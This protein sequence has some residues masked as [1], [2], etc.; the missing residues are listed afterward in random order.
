MRRFLRYAGR[1]VAAA[2]V[3]VGCCALLAAVVVPRIAGATPYTVLT[4]SMRPT[5]PP[6]SI[7]VVRPNQPIALGD[8]I[9]FQL[10]SGEPEVVT[11]RV[12]EI[13]FKTDGTP[14]YRTRGDANNADDR[15]EV[16][17]V[18]IRGVVWYHIPY[19][20][21]VSEAMT[22]QQRHYIV[23]GIAALLVGYAGWQVAQQVRE[24]GPAR[25]PAAH[26]AK[27]TLA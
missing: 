2:V 23:V 17:P 22:G 5:M 13:G 20:G 11:H 1:A 10:K 14:M 21:Y 12:D 19:L 24:R 9:T 27:P 25:R 6:G 7:V 26:K 3:I 4:G 16:F 8:A 15:A 18:Q